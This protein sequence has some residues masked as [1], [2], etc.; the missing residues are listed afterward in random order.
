MRKRNI[1]L[2]AVIAVPMIGLVFLFN[3][4]MIRWYKAPRWRPHL[5]EVYQ[6]NRASF[7]TYVTNIENGVIPK[8]EN[9]QGYYLLDILVREDLS[10]VSEKDGVIRF[11]FFCAGSA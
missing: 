10:C 8:R 2:V 11:M 3:Y 5:V 9:G 6:D 7:T 4:L 1:M